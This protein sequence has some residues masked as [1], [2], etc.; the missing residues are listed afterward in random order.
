MHKTLEPITDS[1]MHALAR[2][3]WVRQLQAELS[4]AG[5]SNRYAEGICCSLSGHDSH[6]TMAI[7]LGSSSYPR[8]VLDIQEENLPD[9]HPP[10]YISEFF[11][12]QSAQSSIPL[13]PTRIGPTLEGIAAH[14][15][16]L[17]ASYFVQHL[18]H[19]LSPAASY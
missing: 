13:G 10:G 17:P 2:S 8:L 16:K 9:L 19:L 15:E 11:L 12:E 6:R 4:A 7:S 14:F 18:Q 1:Q 3:A 5:L